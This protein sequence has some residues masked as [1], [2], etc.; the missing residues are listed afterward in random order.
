LLSIFKPGILRHRKDARITEKIFGS[1]PFVPAIESKDCAAVM[2][3][4]AEKYHE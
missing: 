4:V 1:L 2:K 3:H